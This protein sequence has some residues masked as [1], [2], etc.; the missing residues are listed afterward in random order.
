MFEYVFNVIDNAICPK[1]HFLGKDEAIEIVTGVL[2][3]GTMEPEEKARLLL[4]M[5]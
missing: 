4:G 1:I 3:A 2:A 5:G